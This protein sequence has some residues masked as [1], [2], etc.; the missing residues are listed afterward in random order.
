[1]Q[2]RKNSSENSINL[3]KMSFEEMKQLQ[4]DAFGNSSI[5]W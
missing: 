3:N 5:L 1:M 2:S 4:A